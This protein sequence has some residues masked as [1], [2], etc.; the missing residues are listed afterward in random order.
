LEEAEILTC[1]EPFSDEAAWVELCR[2]NICEYKDGSFDDSTLRSWFRDYRSKWNSCCLSGE[3]H[4]R[5]STKY[6]IMFNGKS[7]EEISN[8]IK[9]L[10]VSRAMK[11]KLR[12]K[13]LSES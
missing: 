8:I 13:Y 12:R 1:G 7:N 11:S 6:N 5:K 9:N 2:G 3:Q 4:I 10:D